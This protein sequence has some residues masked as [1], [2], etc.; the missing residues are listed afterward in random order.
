MMMTTMMMVVNEK[1]CIVCLFLF[2][3]VRSK[4]KRKKEKGEM[5]ERGK[6][7]PQTILLTS[8]KRVTKT[9]CHTPRATMSISWNTNH[10]ITLRLVFVATVENDKRV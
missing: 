9:T 6:K 3:C 1:K 4:E 10:I 8:K 5:R 2:V 7:K